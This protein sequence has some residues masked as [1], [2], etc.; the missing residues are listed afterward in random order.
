MHHAW[1][2][3]V[4]EHFYLVWPFVVALLP[5]HRRRKAIGGLLLLAVAWRAGLVVGGSTEWV[6][7]GTDAN[8]FAILAGCYLAVA[9]AAI[10]R[11]SPGVPAAVLVGL[12]LLPTLEHRTSSYFWGGF[13]V[14]AATCAVIRWSGGGG[15]LT[16]QPLR[17]L[18]QISYG[19]YLWHY[20]LIRLNLFP[21]WQ[22]VGM[23]FALSVVMWHL[24]EQ[25]ILHHDPTRR[26]GVV[27][28]TTEDGS[29]SPE[30]LKANTL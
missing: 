15:W 21:E 2:L 8:A 12:A 20:L 29:E 24:V 5:A 7:Y 9:P 30:A 28:S 18:G 17:Y 3:A 4:E 26:A 27:S 13:L 16:S 19:M 11:W 23:A 1:S 25:P 10:R 22:A 6:Y 14:V